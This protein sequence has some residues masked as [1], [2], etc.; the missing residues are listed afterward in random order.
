MASKPL[1]LGAG[2]AA[3]LIAISG[4][5]LYQYAFAPQNDEPVGGPVD[6]PSTQATF[7]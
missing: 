4:I 6:L 1:W 5:G 7:R 2:V 3:V